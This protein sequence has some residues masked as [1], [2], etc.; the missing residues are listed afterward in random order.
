MSET[1]KITDEVDVALIGAGIVSTTLGAMLREL[2]PDWT[3]MVL[4]RLDGPALESSSPWNNA[5]TGHSALCELNYTPEKNRLL[6]ITKAVNINEKFQVSRQFWSHQVEHGVLGDPKEFINPVPH[7]SLAQGQEQVDYLRRRYD[8]LREHTLFPGMQFTDDKDV[9]SEKLPLMAKG[10]DF[11]EPVAISW[12]ESG[13]DINYGALTRQFVAHAEKAGTEFRYGH[14]VTRIRPDGDKW[15]VYYKNVHTGDRK[16][17]RANFVF[18]GAG[19]YALDLLRSAGLNEVRGI[20]GFPISG[21]WLRC[22]NPEL[23]EQHRAK[24]Y[25]K[26]R[27]GA[28]PMSVPHLDT[29]VIDGEK[30]L[31][32]G[33][34]G[35]W[36]PKFLKKGSY[37]DLFKS[38]RPD[39]IPSYLGVAVQEF[40]L[41]KYLVSEVTKNFDA[42][43]ET[44][45]EYMPTAEGKDWELIVA[46]QRVQVIRPAPAP[47]F[48]SLEFGTAVINN[49]EGSIAGLL[50]A[51]PGASIAPAAMLELLERCFGERMIDWSDKL[52]ELI[53]SYGRKFAVEPELF[54]KTWE[55]TQKTLQLNR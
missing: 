13:T 51:S 20:A 49:S 42:R 32:F 14:E 9:F 33:P 35:G 50:G 22:T 36:T 34:Y 8:T 2:Q 45:R 40:D 38:I 21:M 12:T 1:A 5:G 39:N 37:L 31:L 54:A 3:Q 52:H 48:G 6:D 44:L 47:R 43:M 28:P 55:R 25:G 16:A 46:G 19:G 26:A 15:I 10:R 41:T 7:V 30:G 23:I 11:S 27:V 18:V 24:V 17:V 53:P 4:E 29:R